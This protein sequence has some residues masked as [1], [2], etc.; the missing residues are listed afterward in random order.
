M[1]VSRHRLRSSPSRTLLTFGQIPL[2]SF[3]NP[4][5]WSHHL[6]VQTFGRIADLSLRRIAHS[7]FG[8]PIVCKNNAPIV[9]TSFGAQELSHQ[10]IAPFCMGPLS[11]GRNSAPNVWT[12][13]LLLHLWEVPSEATE[14]LCIGHQ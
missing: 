14:V 12:G 5:V 10:T 7:S 13:L 4:K 3:G 9:W 1:L 6:A 8:A 2:L 11:F